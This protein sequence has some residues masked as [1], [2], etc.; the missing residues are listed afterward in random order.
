MQIIN[1]DNNSVYFRQLNTSAML[2]QWGER[3][4]LERT[5]MGSNPGPG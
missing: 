2:A 3:S 4:P 5:V 1:E